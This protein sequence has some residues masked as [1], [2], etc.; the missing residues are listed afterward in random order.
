MTVLCLIEDRMSSE[1]LQG[2]VVLDRDESR[3]SA[4]LTRFEDKS[5]EEIHLEEDLQ[6]GSLYIKDPR[7]KVLIL[8][9]YSRRKV[10]QDVWD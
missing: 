1:P 8:V 10:L 6:I 4:V 5:S 7:S 9:C 2:E 3:T